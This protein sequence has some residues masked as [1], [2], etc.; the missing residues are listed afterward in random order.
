MLSV[1][2]T[3][4]SALVPVQKFNELLNKYPII[5]DQVDRDELSVILQ[6]LER[7]LED[8]IN[9][10][11][12]EFGCYAGTTSLFIKRLLD[13]YRSNSEFHVYDSFVG[14]P[15]KM[16]QD[17]SPAGEQFKAGEL[18]VSKKEFLFNFKKA[19]LSPPV[20][21]KGWFEDLGDEDVPGG[22]SF[23]FLDGDYY[24]SVKVPLRLIEAKLAQ[25]AVIIIDDY[26]NEALPGA[27]KATN[28]WLSAK[29]YKL[30]TQHS[31]AIIHT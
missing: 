2:F 14:L 21:H 28:E 13:Y 5:T 17:S 10:A 29:Q 25:G 24:S 7:Q 23:A 26:A 30:H 1:F 18:S 27:A 16:G 4:C 11:V 19:N 31:L 20:V 12:V 22:I 8:N 6:L 15:E 3:S 9:G